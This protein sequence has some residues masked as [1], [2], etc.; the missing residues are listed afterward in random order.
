[1]YANITNKDFDRPV[2]II[3][4]YEQVPH[5]D[6]DV[7]SDAGLFAHMTKNIDTW[8]YSAYVHRYS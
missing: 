6:M 3:C 5:R 7:L 1:M 4:A 2:L 8:M